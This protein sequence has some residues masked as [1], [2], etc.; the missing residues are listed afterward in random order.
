MSSSCGCGHSSDT[1]G[2]TP[3]ALTLTTA[4]TRTADS[5]DAMAE[6]RVMAGTP[7]NKAEAEAKGLYRDH[8]GQ[9]YWFCCPGCAPKFDADPAR[10]A[11]TA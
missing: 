11:Y 9:R 4:P 6:C 10:Y 7:V 1:T 3:E 5:S 2:T 8:E